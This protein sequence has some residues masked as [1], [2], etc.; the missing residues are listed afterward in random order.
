[1]AKA[2]ILNESETLEELQIILKNSK[3]PEQKNRIRAIIMVKKGNKTLTEIAKEFGIYRGTL[4]E[5]IQK[6]NKEKS[7]GLSLSKGGR[8]LGNLKWEESLFTALALEISSH[9]KYWSVP[10]MKKWLIENHQQDI[11]PQTIWYHMKR[12][13]LSFKTV[14]PHPYLGNKVLQEDF[15]KGA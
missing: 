14:R 4:T 8:P 5:W 7:T 3:D 15:K 10:I 13:N 11:P 6:Y 9:K 2:T 12:K 1:M